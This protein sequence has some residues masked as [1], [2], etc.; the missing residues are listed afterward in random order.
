[1]IDMRFL[2]GTE[3]I[4]VRVKGK[5]LFFGK[6]Q[7]YG[8]KLC[9]LDG[10]KFSV[11]G[12]LKEFPE[13]EKLSSKE[14]VEEGKKRFREHIKSLNSEIEILDYLKK[15]LEKHGYILKMYIRQGHRPI[16]VK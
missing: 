11:G 15:D 7:G 5:S 12:V 8:I 14:I 6:K 13:L 9:G 2:K 10:L 3:I 4:V 16:Y 1:M